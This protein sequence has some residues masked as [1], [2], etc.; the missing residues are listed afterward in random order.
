MNTVMCTN[1]LVNHTQSYRNLLSNKHIRQKS[2]VLLLIYKLIIKSQTNFGN[3]F[4][5]PLAKGVRKNLEWM[6]E[7]LITNVCW[8]TAKQSRIFQ[9]EFLCLI[10]LV[11]CLIFIISLICLTA[12][13]F[14][15]ERDNNRRT[16]HILSPK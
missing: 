15:I 13:T 1:I 9:F 8:G 5:K 10:C 2:Q 6:R 14:S 12:G 11:S 4:A 7:R 3:I 16:I